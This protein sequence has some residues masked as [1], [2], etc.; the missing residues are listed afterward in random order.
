MSGRV[1]IQ[2]D[3]YYGWRGLRWQSPRA[4]QNVLDD[5]KAEAERPA[6]A[7]DQVLSDEEPPQHEQRMPSLRRR[8]PMPGTPGN[9]NG[10][11]RAGRSGSVGTFWSAL[12]L[13]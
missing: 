6:A 3:S 5:M 4:L 2:K 1:R 10:H 8:H 13:L 9:R 12:S 7:S 11:H